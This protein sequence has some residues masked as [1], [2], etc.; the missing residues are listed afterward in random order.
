MVKIYSDIEQLP[1][2]NYVQIIQNLDYKYLLFD[3]ETKITA[4]IADKIQESWDN[5]NTE[6]ID[7]MGVPE[8]MQE[9]LRLKKSI[10]LLRVEKIKT[11]NNSLESIIEIKEKELQ[12]YYENNNKT[13][14]YEDITAVE[15]TLKMQIDLQKTSLKRYLSYIKILQKNGRRKN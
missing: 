1:L 11:D 10:A 14:I 4:E 13:D 15:M 7:Y 5:I 8:Q 3:I 6:I 9:L 12:N 2:F